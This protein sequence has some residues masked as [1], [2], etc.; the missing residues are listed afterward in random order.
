MVVT[1]DQ[2]VER[3]LR[4][5]GARYTRTRRA[6]I[7]ALARSDGPR[8]AGELHVALHSSVPLSSLYRSLSVLEDAGVVEPHFAVKGL[9]R[10]ELAEWIAGHHH[11]LVCVSCGSVEDIEIPPVLEAGITELVEE[12]ASLV[13]FAAMAHTL[14]I[15]GRCAAC[16]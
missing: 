6:V 14:E 3:R 10:F 5:H 1:L 4:E 9:T 8:S 16:R 7:R 2:T 12:I 15:E 11:H 13:S